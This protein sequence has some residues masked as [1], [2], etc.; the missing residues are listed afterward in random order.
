VQEISVHQVPGAVSLLK[1]HMVLQISDLQPGVRVLTG[2][3]K[4]TSGD[5]YKVQDSSDSECYTPQSGGTLYILL[6]NRI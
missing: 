3:R 6:I 5:L 1:P 2:V 4:D